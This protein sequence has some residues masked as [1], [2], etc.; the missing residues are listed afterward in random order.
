MIVTVHNLAKN[1]KL[2][3]SEVLERGTTF[4]LYVLDTAT[5]YI[6]YQQDIADGKVVKKDNKLSQQEMLDMIQRAR[7]GK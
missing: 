6:R 3:P 2:L 4:D 7:S 1:Y 5:R